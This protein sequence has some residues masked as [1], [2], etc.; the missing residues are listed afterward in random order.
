[1]H[2]IDTDRESDG[3]GSKRQT[4]LK[5]E[6]LEARLARLGRA[7]IAFSGGVDST[8]LLAVAVKVLGDRAV[9]FTA[10]SPSLH[11][12]EL[13][14][15]RAL[16]DDLGAT[17]CEVETREMEDSRYRENNP[18][19]C[20]FCKT[21]LFTT[22]SE[23]AK[24]RGIDVVLDG[25]NL[26]D[27]RDYRPGLEA[28]REFGVRSPLIEVGLTKRE[29]RSLARE[30]GLPVWDKPAMPCLASRIP[31]FSPVTV[32]KLDQIGRAEQLLRTMGFPVVR[33]RH[34][35]EVARIEVEP[36]RIADLVAPTVRERVE[37]ALE[38]LGFAFVTVDLSGYRS[39]K[40][41]RV[42]DETSS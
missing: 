30:Q 21:H 17:H 2:R 16:A 36:G 18:R 27:T 12:E 26:D 6:D 22:V 39:G 20:Y 41:N 8:F 9:A 35:G 7:A 29:I 1:M 33:V 24:E 31:Y 10:V 13:A 40:L 15:A 19:R 11:P 25:N 38:A 34:H 5:L 37:E 28:S 32:E 14:E 4:R 42:L 23:A 3:F